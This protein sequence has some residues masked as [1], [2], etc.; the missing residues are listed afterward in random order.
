LFNTWEY[1]TDNDPF[2]A[3]EYPADTDGDGTP[4]QFDDDDDGDSFPDTLEAERGTDPLDANETPLSQYGDNSGI[5]WVPGEGF[6][7]SYNAEA[8]EFSVS[9][10]MDMMS[11][12]YLIPLLLLPITLLLLLRRQRR[13]TKMRKDMESAESLDDLEGAE[14]AIDNLIIKRKVKVV[15]GVLLR[16]L[17]ERKRDGMSADDGGQRTLRDARQ[18]QAAEQAAEQSAWA[19]PET[20]KWS[21]DPPVGGDGRY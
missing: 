13:F 19:A 21:N 12:E 8:Y 3:D 4:D 18:E 16:N 7:S 15:H 5:Y 6:S 11:S 17:F 14:E 2:D 1:Q 10:L 9:A 20:E